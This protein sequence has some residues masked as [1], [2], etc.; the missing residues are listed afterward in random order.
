MKR[1]DARRAAVIE[2]TLRSHLAVSMLRPQF[3]VLF[4]TDDK[5][6]IRFLWTSERRPT[7]ATF[8]VSPR[9]HFQRKWLVVVPRGVVLSRVVRHLRTLQLHSVMRT[10]RARLHRC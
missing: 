9:V 3:P 7:A 5:F 4:V 8:L 10:W 6:W 2:H 1:A